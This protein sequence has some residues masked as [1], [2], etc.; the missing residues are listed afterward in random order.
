MSHPDIKLR[1]CSLIWIMFAFSLN[2]HR[3]VSTQELK[4]WWKSPSSLRSFSMS[5]Y[6]SFSRC[7]PRLGGWDAG[8]GIRCKGPCTHSI[9]L[10]TMSSGISLA[11]PRQRNWGCFYCP[12][13]DV[14]PSSGH[15][16]LRSR[17]KEIYLLLPVLYCIQTLHWFFF[18]AEEQKLPSSR[19]TITRTRKE[20]F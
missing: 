4:P 13:Q 18:F 3:E 19:R 15:C 2:I 14:I 7:V 12:C 17:I 16:P 6:R 1:S 10:L 5:F 11:T 8:H 20:P 9:I